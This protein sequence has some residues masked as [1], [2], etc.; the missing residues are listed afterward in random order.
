MKPDRIICSVDVDRDVYDTFQSIV[1]KHGRN[2]KGSIT[3][4]MESVIRY[5]TPNP[6]TIFA[7]QE[8]EALKKNP[9]KKVYHSFSEVL[10][11]LAN[12]ED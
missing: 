2:V 9:N 6:D 4:Y 3:E 8:A 10:E 7:I 12:D 11:E 5:D 1:R